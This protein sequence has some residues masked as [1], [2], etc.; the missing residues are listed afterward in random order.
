M[1]SVFAE[2]MQKRIL[3]E[4]ADLS[5]LENFHTLI[6]VPIPLAQKRLRERGFNQALLICEKLTK[7][8][9]NLKQKNILWK[10]KK[11]PH[12]ALIENRTERLKNIVGSFGVKNPDKI[13]GKNV[14]LIDDVT[15]TGATLSEA[16]KVLREAGE[17]KIIAFTIA[18]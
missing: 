4:L 13:K 11:T 5:Q 3:E 12:Q 15:T 8:N 7:Q 1:A 16:R 2:A 18:H 9:T 6:L 10:Q 17:K 14:I